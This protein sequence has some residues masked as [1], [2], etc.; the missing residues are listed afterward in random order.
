MAAHVCCIRKAAIKLQIKNSEIGSYAAFSK[1]KSLVI[2]D[3]GNWKRMTF[4]YDMDCINL[5]DK[6]RFPGSC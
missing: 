1:Q 3:L 5:R 2:N 6:P 4:L